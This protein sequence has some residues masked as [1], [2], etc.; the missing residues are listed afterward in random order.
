MEDHRPLEIFGGKFLQPCNL[1]VWILLKDDPMMK[2]WIQLH[3]RILDVESRPSTSVKMTS[4]GRAVLKSRNF[5][6]FLVVTCAQGMI[7]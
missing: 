7:S 1:D 3:H 4:S 5:V 2:L 6:S